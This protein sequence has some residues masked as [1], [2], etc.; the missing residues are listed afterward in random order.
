MKKPAALLFL[1]LFTLAVK[2]NCQPNVLKAWEVYEIE[3]KASILIQNP[4]V[5]CLKEGNAPYASAEFTGTSGEALNMKYNIPAFW[6]GN[7]IW[8]IRFAPPCS[9]TW[10]FE[11]YS[12][13]KGLAKKKGQ[14]V[15]SDWTPDDLK[16]N[17]THRGFIQVNKKE[18]RA[19]RYFVYSDGTP[20]LWISDTWWDWTNRKIKFESFKELVDTRSEQGFNIG[21]LFFAGNGWSKESSLLDD[22]WQHP[23]IN[24]IRKVEKMIAYANSKGITVWIHAWWSRKDLKTTIGE[25]NMR[26]WWRYVIDRLHAYNVIWVLAGEFNMD[27]YGGFQLEFWNKLGELIKSEDPYDRIVGVHP[28]PPNW[29][30]GAEAPQWSTAATIHEQPWLDYNQSQCGHEPWCNQYIPEIIKSAY[31]KQPAKPVVVTEPWY[32]FI[33]GNPTAMDIRFGAWSAFMSGA[34]GHTYGGGHTWLAYLPEKASGGGSWPVDKS[35]NVNTLYYP[36]AVSMGFMSK[37][38]NGMKWWELAPHPEFVLE[39]PSHYC[40]ANPGKE[41]LLFLR[42]GGSFKLDLTDTSVNDKFNFEW[43]D[44]VNNKIDRK[45]SVTGG[46][47][48]EFKCPED[49]P[50]MLNFK[51]WVVH[52]YKE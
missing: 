44:L 27:N 24:Q 50:R 8:K 33:E 2:S 52:I 30:G 51:D 35:F 23:D 43:V 34:A 17:A 11:T 1:L 26:H 10:K 5:E 21:Q 25:E 13:D 9:G 37:Y 46:K 4:Y 38:L 15:V 6:D 42:Y 7:S 3:L 16:T 48:S 49:Y 31:E 32:E 12:K 18:P 29:K 14:I 19:G 45:G 22:T 28:T 20:C 40:T 47:I 41:Y 36:G 39:N